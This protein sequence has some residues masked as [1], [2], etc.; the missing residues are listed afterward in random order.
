MGNSE[1][2]HLTIGAGRIIFQDLMRVNEEIK[3]G[4]MAKNKHLIDLL[5]STAKKPQSNLHFLG[6]VSN[7]GVHSHIDHLFSLLQIAKDNGLKNISVHAF[8]TVGIHLPRA[9]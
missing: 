6:L 8:W 4:R 1:V 9:A 3:S 2:G 5:K 7:G